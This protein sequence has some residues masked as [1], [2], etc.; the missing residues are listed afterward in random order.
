MGEPAAN[1]RPELGIEALPR[2]PH[3]AVVRRGGAPP[4]PADSSR[5]R[6][7][8]L[9]Q[10]FDGVVRGGWPEARPNDSARPLSG[11]HAWKDLPG[12]EMDPVLPVRCQSVEHRVAVP[13]L[14]AM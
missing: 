4:D 10:E 13:V 9:D 3:A 6:P 5:P 14:V 2:D 1:I 8:L 7:A 11:Q 12:V